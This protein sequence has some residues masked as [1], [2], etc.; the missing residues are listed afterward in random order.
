MPPCCLSC[1]ACEKSI[2]EAPICHNV[3]CRASGLVDCSADSTCC[4]NALSDSWSA[5]AQR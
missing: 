3:S 4:N 1:R 5:V 2:T